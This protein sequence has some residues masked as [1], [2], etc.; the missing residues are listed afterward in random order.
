MPS[1]RTV[2]GTEDIRDHFDTSHDTGGLD[3][4]VRGARLSADERQA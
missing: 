4:I 2:L 3:A 1:V